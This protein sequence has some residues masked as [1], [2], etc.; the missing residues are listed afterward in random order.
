MNELWIQYSD[1]MGPILLETSHVY[2]P[3]MDGSHGHGGPHTRLT[4]Q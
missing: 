1:V 3:I 4:D 2:G